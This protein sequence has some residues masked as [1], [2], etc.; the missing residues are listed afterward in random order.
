MEDPI[1]VYCDMT[2]DG[3]GWIKLTSARSRNYWLVGWTDSVPDTKCGNDGF[4]TVSG[5]TYEVDYTVT[6]LT[7]AFARTLSDMQYT[8]EYRT[9][10]NSGTTI[11]TDDQMDAIRA[12]TSQVRHGECAHVTG[13]KVCCGASYMSRAAEEVWSR[14]TPALRTCSVHARARRVARFDRFVYI[15]F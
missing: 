7:S 10:S 12:S 6:S 8:V 9:E 13:R 2:T 15:C 1:D 14:G 4:S 3:G 5:T 11:L